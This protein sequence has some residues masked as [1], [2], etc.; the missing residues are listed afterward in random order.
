MKAVKNKK[1]KYPGGGKVRSYK[2]GQQGMK[3]DPPRYTKNDLRRQVEGLKA[4][5]DK[6]LAADVVKGGTMFAKANPDLKGLTQFGKDGKVAGQIRNF[7]DTRIKNLE[8]D[9]AKNNPELKPYNREEFLQIIK[10]DLQ[11]TGQ[12]PKD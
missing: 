9:F 4:E 8:A 12:I 7:Y 5:R 10:E 3:T 2:V 1:N 11:K 6:M